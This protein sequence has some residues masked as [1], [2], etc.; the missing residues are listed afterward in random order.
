[1]HRKTQKE[2]KKLLSHF[3]SASCQA[4]QGCQNK[5]TTDWKSN[6]WRAK[7]NIL[8]NKISG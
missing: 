3:L 4:M 6:S 8:T 2:I 1:V 7:D 5:N